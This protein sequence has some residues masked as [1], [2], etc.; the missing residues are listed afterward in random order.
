MMQDEE[1][2]EADEGFVSSFLNEDFRDQVDFTGGSRR[3]F[4]DHSIDGIV[5]IGSALM[6]PWTSAYQASEQLEEEPPEGARK[7]PRLGSTPP[8]A[9]IGLYAGVTVKQEPGAPSSSPFFF[10]S[11]L[12]LDHLF[13]PPVALLLCYLR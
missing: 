7:A 4:L 5:S 12:S 1:F 9:A 3:S 11:T 10:S 6:T 2:T 8:A 13:D